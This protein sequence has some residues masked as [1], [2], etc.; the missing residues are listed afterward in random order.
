MNR[1]SHKRSAATQARTDRI[2]P[3]ALLLHACC[4]PCAGGV[5]EAL[6]DA[7]VAV[8]VWFDNSNIHPRS[9]YE[10]RLDEMC[11]FARRL[12]VPL[13]CA[14]YAPSTWL[15]AMKDLEDCPERGERCDHCFRWRLESSAGLAA[16]LGISAFATTLG[17]S[18][19][20]NL[21]QV[22][23]AG[24]AAAVMQ[25]GVFFLPINW[26]KGGGAQRMVE[27]AR[28]EGFY[29]QEYC[30]CRFSLR[31]GNAWRLAR[32]RQPIASAAE[33]LSGR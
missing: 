10:R 3:P 17:I 30:G 23:A 5:L 33:D 16:R 4:A 20:K 22:N 6:L 24:R 8:T 1:P 15:A 7:A 11:R 12:G 27:V 14:D 2:L 9:E 28:R 25:S 21:D 29:Q 13:L 31:D 32:G 18:R 26:R 19:W